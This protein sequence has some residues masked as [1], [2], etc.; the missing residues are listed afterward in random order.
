MQR[1]LARPGPR[2]ARATRWASWSA[3]VNTPK[4]SGDVVGAAVGYPGEGPDERD[5]LHRGRSSL[6]VRA[7]FWGYVGALLVPADNGARK[8]DADA[9]AAYNSHPPCVVV[10]LL[11][12]WGA[13]GE[14]GTSCSAV[15]IAVAGDAAW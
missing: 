1:V 5:E 6:R 2:S 10:W 15:A 7:A 4:N 13:V 8:A 11:R 9:V 3:Q 14:D 12:A